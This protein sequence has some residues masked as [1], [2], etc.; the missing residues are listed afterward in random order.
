MPGVLVL[1]PVVPTARDPPGAAGGGL[2]LAEVQLPNLVR[3][4]RVVRERCLPPFGQ[5]PAFPLVVTGQDQPLV[6]QDPQHRRLGHDMPVVADHRPDLAMSP[7]RMRTR[8]R[9]HA[10]P[11]GI[12]G[13]TRPRTLDLSTSTGLGL[14]AAPSPFRD[15]ELLAPPRGRHPGL[16]PDHLEVLEGPNLPSA[17]FFH[18]LASRWASPSA[19][20]RSATSASSCCSRV[21]GP[22]RPAAS[23]VF[24]A[25]RK[26]AF[27]RPIDCSDTFSRR[28]ASAIVISPA[29]TLSTIRVFRSAG[30]T[31]GLPMVQILLQD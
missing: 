4:G 1:G 7:R 29:S 8:V 28:A 13:R 17:D 20:V 14:P 2:E 6:P 27:H 25:S 19:W 3:A 15:A 24:P 30:I 12:T 21:D 11:R 18:T 26:S 31:G 23:A 22:D 16:D 5:L 10:F 9:Q